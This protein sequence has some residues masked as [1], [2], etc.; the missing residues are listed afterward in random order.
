MDV[1]CIVFSLSRSIPFLIIGNYVYIT[2]FILIILLC[3]YSGAAASMVNKLDIF[4]SQKHS[5]V[6]GT[7]HKLCLLVN[8]QLKVKICVLRSMI[9]I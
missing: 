4:A 2:A 8:L 9:V 7:V 6:K 1:I 3:F 5:L